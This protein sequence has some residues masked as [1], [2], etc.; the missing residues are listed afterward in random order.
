[1]GEAAI[2]ALEFAPG[3]IVLGVL[4]FMMFK[5][6]RISWSLGCAVVGCLLAASSPWILSWFVWNILEVHTAN[7]GAAALE[8]AQPI[9][10]PAAAGLGALVGAVIGAAIDGPND[11]DADK[12]GDLPRI[13]QVVN[14]MGSPN[15]QRRESNPGT[16]FTPGA[17]A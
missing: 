16:R 4:I 11:F 13:R 14:R 10:V 9:L 2:Y 1:M 6:G 12:R 5:Q 3:L 17:G 7:F 15:R 8:F